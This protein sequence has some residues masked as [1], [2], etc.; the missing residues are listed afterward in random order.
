MKQYE[1]PELEVVG[2]AGELT[3]GGELWPSPIDLITFCRGF[4]K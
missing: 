1:A 2:E 4:I 3:L